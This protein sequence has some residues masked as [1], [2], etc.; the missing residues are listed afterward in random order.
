MWIEYTYIY[1]TRGLY[2]TNWF[3]W[4]LRCRSAIR[5]PNLCA[6][7]RIFVDEDNNKNNN[8]NPLTKNGNHKRERRKKNSRLIS[9]LVG[10]AWLP[11]IVVVR[12][13]TESQNCAC[14]VKFCFLIYDDLSNSRRCWF[15]YIYCVTLSLRRTT[16]ATDKRKQISS[17]HR[18]TECAKTDRIQ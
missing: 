18:H 12:A 7:V 5:Q 14:A 17:H 6:L 16:N 9:V 13:W 2:Q 10:F 3:D 15:L 1:I 8:K 11:R 4:V